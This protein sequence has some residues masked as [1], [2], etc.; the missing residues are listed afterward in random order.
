ML[1]VAKCVSDSMTHTVLDVLSD[2]GK[3][4]RIERRPSI[5]RVPGALYEYHIDNTGEHTGKRIETW[6]QFYNIL[7]TIPEFQ[8]LNGCY[9]TF[10]KDVSLNGDDSWGRYIIESYG[11]ELSI[12]HEAESVISIISKILY[13]LNDDNG[14]TLISQLDKYKASFDGDSYYNAYCRV[15]SAVVKN[16]GLRVQDIL[17]IGREKL[18]EDRYSYLLSYIFEII[19]ESNEFL[20]EAIRIEPQIAFEAKNQKERELCIKA[21]PKDKISE[22][23]CEY[24]SYMSEEDCLR[25]NDEYLDFVT[26]CAKKTIEAICKLT[27][28]FDLEGDKESSEVYEYA[29]RFKEKLDG[30]KRRYDKDNQLVPLIFG[31]GDQFKKIV[32]KVGIFAGHNFKYWDNEILLKNG[33]QIS[34]DQVWDTLEVEIILDGHQEGKRKN[35]ALNVTNG[36]YAEND[37]LTTET[38]FR[39]QLSRIVCS[40]ELFSNIKEIIPQAAAK[41]IQGFQQNILKFESLGELVINSTYDELLHKSCLYDIVEKK[42]LCDKLSGKNEDALLIADYS[43]WP[44]IANEILDIIFHYSDTLEFCNPIDCEKIK[45]DFS[46]YNDA[47][48]KYVLLRACNA[49]RENRH[50]KICDIP[51]VI[52][53]HE[54]KINGGKEYRFRNELINYIISPS[55]ECKIHCACSAK[56]VELLL[57]GNYHNVYLIGSQYRSDDIKLEREDYQRLKATILSID[58]CDDF[59]KRIDLNEEISKEYI[60]S[61]SKLFSYWA[62]QPQP[63]DFVIKRLVSNTRIKEYS[64]DN[65]YELLSKKPEI[66]FNDLVSVIK[67][68]E[69]DK[70]SP[71]DAS[72][73]NRIN[74]W[75]TQLD[76]ILSSNLQNRIIIVDN[77]IEA[78]RLKRIL[79]NKCKVLFNKKESLYKRLDKIREGRYDLGITY[80]EEIFAEAKENLNTSFSFILNDISLLFSTEDSLIASL[81]ELYNRINEHSMGSKLFLVNPKPIDAI[82]QCNVIQVSCTKQLSDKEINALKACLVGGNFISEDEVRYWESKETDENGNPVK[83]ELGEML[84]WIEEQLLDN[85]YYPDKKLRPIQIAAI[86]KPITNKSENNNYLTII[87]TG[88]GKSAIFQGPILYKSQ[89]KPGYCKLN[90]VI[91]PLQALMK[92]QVDN[93]LGIP[94][95]LEN[96]SSFCSTIEKIYSR[97]QLEKDAKECLRQISKY[98]KATNKY[99][100]YRVIEQ[101]RNLI[102]NQSVKD[103]KAI[104]NQSEKIEYYLKK[105]DCRKNIVAFIN[106]STSKEEQREIINRIHEHQLTLLYI[107]PERLMIRSFFENV[108]SAASKDQGIDSVIFDEAHCI[109]GWGMDFR[110]SYVLALRKILQLQER[111]SSISV[112]MFTATLPE[113]CRIELQKEIIIDKENIIP[114]IPEYE[115]SRCIIRSPQ[116]KEYYESLCPIRKHI[117]ISAKRIPENDKECGEQNK[118]NY[119]NEKIEYVYSSIIESKYLDI[120][121]L[122]KGSKNKQA[123]ANDEDPAPSRIIIF[124]YSHDNAKDGSELLKAMF[125]SLPEDG[126]KSEA[127]VLSKKIGYFHAGLKKNEKDEIIEKYRDGRILILFSTKAFGLGMDIPNI[128]N[129]IHLTPP[130]FIEDYLQEVGRAGRDTESKEYKEAFPITATGERET[131]KAVCLYSLQDIKKNKDRIS[132]ISWALVTHAYSR[133]LEYLNPN[134]IDNN[135]FYAIPIDLLERFPI[136]ESVGIKE[137][138]DLKEL[139]QQCLSWLSK[140]TTKYENIESPGLNCIEIGYGCPDSFDIEVKDTSTTGISENSNLSLLLGSINEQGRTLIIAN[141]LIKDDRYHDVNNVYDVEKI[142]DEGVTYG[143]FS[144]DY[145]YVSISLINKG[146]IGKLIEGCQS[147]LNIVSDQN[148]NLEQL[149]T[150]TNSIINDCG[151]TK[152][153]QLSII[154]KMDDLSLDDPNKSFED[155]RQEAYNMLEISIN[156]RNY[157]PNKSVTKT[158]W[159]FINEIT[160]LYPLC[161]IIKS[162]YK[163]LV[164]A[165]LKNA[166]AISWKTITEVTGT[167]NDPNLA[168][169]ILLLL[170]ELHLI[171]LG[172][173]ATDYIE[174]RVKDPNRS[175]QE[176]PCMDSPDENCE[177]ELKQFYASKEKKAGAMCG[178]IELM[179]SLNNEKENNSSEVISAK[180]ELIKHYNSQ[181]V[182][183]GELIEQIKSMNSSDIAKQYIKIYSE[184]DLCESGQS[185]LQSKF[186]YMM[187]AAEKLA[188]TVGSGEREQGKHYELDEDQIKIYNEHTAQNINVRAGAG[189]GKTRLLAYWALKLILDQHRNPSEIL[190]LTY[191]RAVRNE[192][193]ERIVGYSETVGRTVLPKVYTFHEFALANVKNLNKTHK[194]C[195]G[196]EEALL[197]DI[198]K[199]TGSHKYHYNYILIDE[200]QD[201]TT[202]RLE[203]V[204]RLCESTNSSGHHANMF[205]VGDERQSIYGYEKKNSVI[206]FLSSSELLTAIKLEAENSPEYLGIPEGKRDLTTLKSHTISKIIDILVTKGDLENQ[207]KKELKE[208]ISSILSFDENDGSLHINRSL[209]KQCKESKFEIIL[210]SISIEPEQYYYRLN[211]QSDQNKSL[212]NNYRS[213]Q[214]IIDLAKQ[215]INNDLISK[216]SYQPKEEC[217]IC[218]EGDWK[219]IFECNGD[220]PSMFETKIDNLVKRLKEDENRD[221]KNNPLE[222]GILFRSNSELFIAYKWLIDWA[223]Q[224]SNKYAKPIVQGADI[225]YYRT[226]E[227]YFIAKLF[228]DKKD[229]IAVESLISSINTENLSE[230]KGKKFDE[231]ILKVAKSLAKQIIIKNPGITFAQL[232][233]KFEYIA[234]REKDNLKGVLEFDTDSRIKLI[235]ST[236]HKVKGMEYDAVIVPTSNYP[237][238]MVDDYLD[239]NESLMEEKRLMY[240][241]YTRAK[242]LL[243]YQNG[244]REKCIKYGT[245]FNGN[246]NTNYAKNDLSKVNISYLADPYHVEEMYN[247]DKCQQGDALILKKETVKKDNGENVINDDGSIR[248]EWRLYVE[249]NGAKLLVGRLSKDNKIVKNKSKKGWPEIKA[250]NADGSIIEYR[251]LFINSVNVVEYDKQEEKY[252]KKWSDDARNLGYIYCID[253]YGCITY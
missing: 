190:L 96:A 229:E 79:A 71:T 41:R 30:V 104:S 87:P 141:D 109:T 56:A 200:F 25:L 177:N 142:I 9:K 147:N 121:L 226:R 36:H 162:S 167:Q 5:C 216:R 69:N 32:K 125:S 93:I 2:S 67:N 58:K 68:S 108:I 59:V 217:T 119:F 114:N 84:S 145:M 11:A 171:S 3:V 153:S 110:P 52:L 135:K 4:N 91:S 156:E 221:I 6:F 53:K 210:N 154:L 74:F 49:L 80:L 95:L 15:L 149:E 231:D 233:E 249:K 207:K 144:K 168:K 120:N 60:P 50:L 178:L 151:N 55:Q 73:G 99:T 86:Q 48:H 245:Q 183:D 239:S 138:D 88:G 132:R 137:N 185:I 196:W 101:L 160:L 81:Y 130:S 14:I 31:D 100:L 46:I 203:I 208:A 28:T 209:S 222:V 18:D 64:T 21:C 124:T 44:Q 85:K 33:I 250:Q 94:A 35:F 157:L 251:G 237:T 193:E 72:E 164:T 187:V 202:T 66:I 90:I 105:Y 199:N 113:Q 19:K 159:Q 201:V 223:K 248:T 246:Q 129:V 211:V 244:D 82:P 107:A 118:N 247:L 252:Q 218:I 191:N 65:G 8:K 238:D 106:S 227:F 39:Q 17:K 16:N 97:E 189:S 242:S 198:I 143:K 163:L 29:Y 165:Y 194:D 212:N 136:P 70:F 228:R 83:R 224:H 175:I 146:L 213:Y 234:R 115:N 166:R 186:D 158:A 197:A 45:E 123:E 62:Y 122:L 112:H 47:F 253:Y 230:D 220:F 117:E 214:A 51:D 236:I 192:L 24:G 42:E 206:D 170:K 1:L 133:I 127:R 179:K 240:V 219:T 243:F 204:K 140:Q 37:V 150:I 128:H 89:R 10:I 76:T 176:T 152:L 43:Y 195:E 20:K 215:W 57:S 180:N 61:Y 40:P 103:N 161:D 225:H 7:K 34:N 182:V 38:L 181:R 134:S 22:V 12:S 139:F 235:L 13:L 205:V 75:R 63:G 102:G 111:H 148:V 92:D 169:I 78:E 172:G 23:Q 232:L 27:C 54:F 126:E 184:T 174:I 241:A 188:Q 98:K 116:D 173:F 131:I 155:L 26:A 77:L